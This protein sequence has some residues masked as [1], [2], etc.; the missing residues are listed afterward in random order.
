ME[1]DTLFGLPA[2]PLLVHGAVV[3]M[4]LAVLGIVAIAAVPRWRRVGAPLVFA[5]AVA[6]FG[7]IVVARG[8]GEPFEDRIRETE[9][10]EEHTE[11]GDDILPWTVGPVVVAGALVALE[12]RS[13]RDD[14]LATPAITGAVVAV[15]VLIGGVAVWKLVEVGHSGAK[16]AWSATVDAGSSGGDRGDDDRR[17]DDD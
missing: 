6:A 11:L 14:R 15:A 4:P 1:I 13:R 5:A 10:V 8:S 12:R 2:H 16:A 3:L 7:A 17:G 9:L